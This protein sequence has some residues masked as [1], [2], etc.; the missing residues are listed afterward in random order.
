MVL[1]SFFG[2]GGDGGGGVSRSVRI[3]DHIYL[4]AC[5]SGLCGDLGAFPGY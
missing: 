4:P 5:F 3:I 2:S 1:I